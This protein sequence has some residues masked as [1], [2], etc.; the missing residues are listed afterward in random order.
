MYS[1]LSALNWTLFWQ[2]KVYELYYNNNTFKKGEGEEN[3]DAALYAE[4]P[5]F[6]PYRVFPACA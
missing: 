5:S 6:N 1:S 3:F 2:E 4:S